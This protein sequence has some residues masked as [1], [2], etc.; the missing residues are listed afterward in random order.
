VLAGIAILGS[1][2]A[3]VLLTRSKPP[4]PANSTPKPGRSIVAPAA[5][6]IRILAGSSRPYVDRFGQYWEP[7][8]WF[9]GGSIAA[10]ANHPIFGTR[11]PK[12]YQS[13]R[14]GAFRY[15]IPLKPGAYELRLHLAET[16]YGDTNIAGGGESSRI[17]NVKINGKTLLDPADVI[18]D[19]GP[20]TADIRAFKNVQPAPDGFL[21]LDFEP[22]TNLAILNALEITP[23]I[24]GK[25]NPIRITARDQPYT[26]KSGRMWGP[27]RFFR[28]GL[29]VLRPN[30]VM[31]AG[32]PEIFRGERFGNLTYAIPVADGRYTVNLYFAETWFGPDKPQKG[33][34]GS[35]V[36]DVLCN[37]VAM[38]RH[39][40]I[41]KEAGGSDRLLTKSFHGVKPNPQGKIVI[42]FVPIRNY[43]CVNA[44]EVLDE[45]EK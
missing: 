27:D 45:S 15:D 31:G 9:Q 3:G 37:G 13:R 38:A 19:A 29:Q 33:G 5:D 16:V 1:I 36:F 34:V 14:E 25:L 11:D 35:R 30:A 39:T 28:G 12:L 6:Q 17:F 21:H 4:D 23:G 22:V 24:M 41:Y 7:D 42:S 20:N 2:L 10:D 40:D 32:E 8:R 43:A 26:D 18:A 44:I